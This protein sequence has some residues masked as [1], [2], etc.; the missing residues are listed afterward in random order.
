MNRVN[1]FLVGVLTGVLVVELAIII[2]A[3]VNKWS[4]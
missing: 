3:I 2:M 4:V 1:A